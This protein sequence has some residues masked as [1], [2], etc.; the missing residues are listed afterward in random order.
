MSITP[1]GIQEIID[2]SSDQGTINVMPLYSSLPPQQQRQ[3]FEPSQPGI[4]KVV[5]A[6]NIAETSITIDGVVYVVDPGLSKTKVYNPRSHMESLLVSPISRAAATQRTGRAGRTRNG[7]CFRL[8]T[9]DAYEKT[10]IE[11]N[12]P[13]ILRTNIA[14]ALLTLLNLGE[15]SYYSLVGFI[16]QL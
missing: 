12:M 3:V 9:E 14:T 7:K 2:N 15:D 11:A 4:R 6:T 1:S 8:Y 16:L 5:I 10:L 13:E